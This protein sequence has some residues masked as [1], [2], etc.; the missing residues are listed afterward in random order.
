MFKKVVKTDE[1]VHL[2]LFNKKYATAK[3]NLKKKVIPQPVVSNN[4]GEKKEEGEKK[5]G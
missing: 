5:Y 2:R 4:N 1:P 3:T